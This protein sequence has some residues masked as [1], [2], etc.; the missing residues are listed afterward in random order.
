MKDVFSAD[1]SCVLLS[2]FNQMPSSVLVVKHWENTTV[3]SIAESV[4]VS[5]LG[6]L[7]K[8]V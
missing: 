1:K 8:A 5:I 2:E 4:L 3:F 7:R 6:L